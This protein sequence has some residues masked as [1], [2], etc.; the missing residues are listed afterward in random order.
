M[1]LTLEQLAARLEACEADLEAH[2]GYLKAMEY[3]I[4]TLIATH[5]NAKALS[6]SWEHTLVAAADSH[7]GRGGCVFTAGIQ[8]AMRTL[9]GQVEALAGGAGNTH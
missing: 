1:N 4:R 2:R 6:L 7:F 5:P 9:T 3:G 8:Q